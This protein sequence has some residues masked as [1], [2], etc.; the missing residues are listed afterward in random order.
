MA[1]YHIEFRIRGRA[2]KYAKTL[3]YDV[4]KRFRVRGV[5]RRH[6]VPH[7]SLYGPFLTRQQ[8]EVVRRV[9]DVCSKYHSVP[10]IFQGFDYFDN[11]SNKVIYM[12]IVP[13][14]DLTNL[15][16]E[17][18]KALLPITSSKSNEDRKNKE[19][20]KFHSTIAFKDIDTKFNAIWKYIRQKDR[21][22][23]RQCLLRVTM[24]KNSKILY[25]YDLIQHKLLNR[26]EALSRQIFNET[27]RRFRTGRIEE[28]MYDYEKTNTSKKDKTEEVS[29]LN[30]LLNLFR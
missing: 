18:A 5:T 8:S 25:E 7:I 23:I 11:T 27:I 22:N 1:V 13:S 14:K 12:N 10:F 4:G 30:R 9:V 21:P 19:D 6:V 26:R 29:F 16:Y 3:I 20:F 24:I 28:N 17:L 15:R 2:K